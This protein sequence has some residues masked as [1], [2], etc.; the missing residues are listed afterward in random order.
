MT[1]ALIGAIGSVVGAGG[2]VA[3]NAQNA[4][5]NRDNL[6]WQSAEADKSRQFNRQEAQIARQYNS[7]GAVTNRML[8]A[9][10]NPDL[11]YNLATGLQT[12]QQANGGM[13]SAPSSIPMDNPL[14]ASI[15]SNVISGINADIAQQQADNQAKLVDSQSELNKA[16]ANEANKNAGLLQE[17]INSQP[18]VRF[19]IQSSTNLN[20]KQ[21]SL[22]SNQANYVQKSI[23]LIDP[24]IRQLNAYTNLLTAQ[25]MAQSIENMFASRMW[26]QRL[27]ELKASINHL[28]SGSALNDSLKSLTDEEKRQ[29]SESFAYKILGM[30]KY[31]GN[32]DDSEQKNI[33][34]YML[35]AYDLENR[36]LRVNAQISEDTKD[37]IINTN[38]GALGYIGWSMDNIVKPTVGIMSDFFSRKEMAGMSL[39]SMGRFG[40]Q[41]GGFG[42]GA[43]AGAGAGG[44]GPRAGAGGYSPLGRATLATDA[45]GRTTRINR[46]AMQKMSTDDINALHSELRSQYGNYR[47]DK[48]GN[49]I[50][51]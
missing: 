29:L 14:S 28:K 45:Q 38:S 26:E 23:D 11:M 42:A 7:I 48:D 6:S 25:E 31:Y 16:K 43:G 30:K 49:I 15:M 36:V 17:F 9:G 1:N 22:L 3:T 20:D 18:D 47:I 50:S 34:S 35:D 37:F 46:G 12:G 44:F 13:A 32:P 2:Q 4:N 8:S 51:R 40:R 24:Q 39:F 10:Y 21:A 5:I 27:E 41:P 33:M 19:N